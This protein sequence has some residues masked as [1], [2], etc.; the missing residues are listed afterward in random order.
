MFERYTEK[1]RRA[2][3]FG[4]YEASQFGSSFIDTEH[5]L[6]GILRDD[7][8]LVRKVLPKVDYERVRESIGS[9]VKP[10]A[11][12]I[13]TSVDLPLSNEAKRVLMY[14]AEEAGRLNH[15]HIGT[16]HL[17]LGLVREKKFASAELLS[18]FGAELASFRK[19]VEALGE[20]SA[21]LRPRPPI[22]YHRAVTGPEVIAIRGAKRN[23]EDLHREVNRLR[24]FYWEQNSWKPRDIVTKKDGKTFSLDLS[25]AERLPEE[26]VLGPGGWK[27]DY[28][29]ICRCELFES[30]DV[31]HGTGFTNGRDWLCTEC[32]QRFIAGN[33]FASPYSDIT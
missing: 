23:V 17:L 15:R 6:L 27:K 13:P 10:D 30:E 3:F 18:P 11:K 8:E 16:E 22:T 7:K 4:R 24:E 25:L 2:I 29:A 33:F 32:H 28:C 12:S 14:G 19:K 1:A 31:S 21:F 26:F 20:P 5:I 9:C